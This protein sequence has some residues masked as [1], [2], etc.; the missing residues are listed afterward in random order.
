[1]DQRFKSKNR[2]KTVLKALLMDNKPANEIAKDHNVSTNVIY[3]IK[4]RTMAQI[5]E[6]FSG[7]D[8]PGNKPENPGQQ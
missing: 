3:Q 5:R 6:K 2:N 8:D 1:M 4:S 7:S